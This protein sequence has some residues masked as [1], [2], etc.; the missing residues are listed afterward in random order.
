MPNWK[1]V[2]YLGDIWD[3]DEIPWESKRDV[4]VERIKAA[5][6]YR[7]ERGN[8]D[9]D[10]Q[11]IVSE[12]EDAEDLD[13]FDDAWDQLYDWGDRSHRLFVQTWKRVTA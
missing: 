12:L 5:P 10:L 11:W 13:A 1:N 4:V 3:S 9:G 8:E 6:W 2:L 7:D